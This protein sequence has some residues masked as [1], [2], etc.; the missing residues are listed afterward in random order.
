[1]FELVSPPI[2]V[3]V[4][5]LEDVTRGD[6][7]VLVSGGDGVRMSVVNRAILARVLEHLQELQDFLREGTR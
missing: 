5:L 3:P 4:G 1:M 2:V 6:V 7:D